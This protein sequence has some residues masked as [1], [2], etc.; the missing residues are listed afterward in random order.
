MNRRYAPPAAGC[1][2]VPYMCGDEPVEGANVAVAL[3]R[4]LHVWG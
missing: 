2:R 4:S 1:G 3:A